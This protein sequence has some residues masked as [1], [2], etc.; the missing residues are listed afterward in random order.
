M[1]S[2]ESDRAG[3]AFV[4]P[5]RSRAFHEDLYQRLA[6]IVLDLPPLRQR[7]E[8]IPSLAEDTLRRSDPKRGWTLSAS[9]PA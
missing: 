6:G 8:D 4:R 1:I 3:T 9:H 5:S 7:R 2:A